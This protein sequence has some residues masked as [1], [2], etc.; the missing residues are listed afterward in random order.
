MLNVLDL[1]SGIGGFSLGLERAGMTTVA[2][3]EIEDYPRQVLAKHWPGVPIH[4]DIRKLDGTQYRGTVDVIC[5]GFPCQPFSHAGKRGGKDDDRDLWPEMLRVIREVQSP[6]V[7]GENVA[8]FINM[9]LDRTLSDLEDEGYA[10]QTFDIP[11][12]GVGAPHIRHRVWIVAH[13]E[14]KRKRSRQQSKRNER[15]GSKFVESN[16][17]GGDTIYGSETKPEAMAHADSERFQEQ[18]RPEPDAEEHGAI[19]CGSRSIRGPDEQ[20]RHQEGGEATGRDSEGTGPDVGHSNRNR[21]DQRGQGIAATGSDGVVRANRWEPEPPVG[22]VAHG[23][24]SRV[25]R[26]KSLGNA[27]VPQIPEILGRAILNST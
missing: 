15:A 17:S 25:D 24:P 4:S 26:L 7:I 2:F 13:A 18:R 27:V 5:G 10:C 20:E 6:W 11:A 9:E 22:R 23:I 19:E 1:F 21:C 16:G 8:G 3:C 12:C 14:S